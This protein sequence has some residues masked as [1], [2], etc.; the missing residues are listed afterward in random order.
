MSSPFNFV[1][2]DVFGPFMV[3]EGATTRRRAS[4]VK[5]FVLLV[6][7]LASRAIH[8][9]PLAGMDTSSMINALQRFMAVR[10]RCKVICSDRGTNFVGAVSQSLD[11]E[12][13]RRQAQAEGITWE[14]NPVAAS[15]FGGAQERKIGAVRRVLE[16]AMASHKS[17]LSRDDFYTMLQKSAAVVNSTPL[18]S[19]SSDGSDPMPISPSMLLTLKEPDE[20]ALEPMSERDLLAY[21]QRRWRR[22]QYLADVFWKNWR[23]HYLQEL[24][25]R[26]K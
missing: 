11:F 5:I 15:H 22:V 19:V 8:L 2:V 7:C 13:L 25:A 10:G 20:G 21:G 16:A 24:T 1:G 23:D 17:R 12:P 4:S 9:E 18:Y 26:R 6:T 14:F 3:S